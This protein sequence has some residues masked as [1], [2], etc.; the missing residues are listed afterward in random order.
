MLLD[1]LGGNQFDKEDL[2][3]EFATIWD[4][5]ADR[6]T[7]TPQRYSRT[8]SQECPR[9]GTTLN[10]ETYATSPDAERARMKEMMRLLSPNLHRYEVLHFD[11]TY[12]TSLPRILADFH[13][14]LPLLRNLFLLAEEGTGLADL[15]GTVTR[16][17]MKE[18]KLDGWNFV[19]CYTVTDGD[20]F[21]ALIEFS[22]MPPYVTISH[23]HP[24]PDRVRFDIDISFDVLTRLGSLVLDD[25][26]FD[27]AVDPDIDG[28]M[29]AE[30][31]ILSPRMNS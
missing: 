27:F 3:A 9:P 25:R 6:P 29:T 28:T 23:Y 16:Y 15:L 22:D 12:T 11:L 7:Y 21:E 13:D 31:L 30:N 2:D 26:D 1:I 24:P 20:W 19:E 8:Q 18:L 14:P 17:A 10:P 4:P 5:R